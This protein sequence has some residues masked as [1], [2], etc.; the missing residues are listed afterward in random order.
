MGS[1]GAAAVEEVEKMTP[2]LQG[3]G[4]TL[5]MFG[6][7]G[8]RSMDFIRDRLGMFKEE[9]EPGSR[10]WEAV[11]KAGEHIENSLKSGWEKY[12]DSL[13]NRYMGQVEE[14]A[15][16]MG[17]A[18]ERGLGS[19]FERFIAKGKFSI[20]GVVGIVQETFTELLA[21]IASEKVMEKIIGPAVGYMVDLFTGEKGLG[22]IKKDFADFWDWLKNSWAG[23]M[24]SSAL[25]PVASASA[26][27]VISSPL[28]FK[29]LDR[30]FYKD[31][32]KINQKPYPI[33]V[34]NILLFFGV[35]L[36]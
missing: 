20:K 1:S 23:E 26:G 18:I 8:G 15:Y 22:E 31:D 7:T 19:E 36:L 27:V 10:F 32:L 5:G 21:R 2:A 6:R 35:L 4:A 12:M 25:G 16:H 13:H 3:A 11:S 28:S 30:L 29:L 24:M 17:L 9:V 34:L 33:Y 14:F